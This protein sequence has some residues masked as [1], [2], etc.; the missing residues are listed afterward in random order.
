M[1]VNTLLVAAFAAVLSPAA[2]VQATE[3][4]CDDSW[5][6]APCHSWITDPSRDCGFYYASNG[7]CEELGEGCVTQGGDGTDGGSYGGS[8]GWDTPP[9]DVTNPPPLDDGSGTY[10]PTTYPPTTDGGSGECVCDDSD[11]TLPCHNFDPSSDCGYIY[12][13]SGRC[14]ELKEGCVTQYGGSPTTSPPPTYFYD[15]ATKPPSMQDDSPTGG[16]RDC[17]KRTL[18]GLLFAQIPCCE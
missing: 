4:V 15:E 11:A 17:T 2:L 6:T 18:R 14:E 7:M 9:T 13:N 5:D 1:R 3:C 16:C 12:A 8:D 10:S